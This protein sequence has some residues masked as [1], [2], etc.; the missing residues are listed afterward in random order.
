MASKSNSNGTSITRQIS[1][2]SSGDEGNRPVMLRKTTS[3]DKAV[4]FLTNY[5]DNGNKKNISFD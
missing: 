3:E 2:S 1:T 5:L 4:K